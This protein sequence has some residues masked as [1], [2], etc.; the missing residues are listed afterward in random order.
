MD[1]LSV[2]ADNNALARG[3]STVQVDNY[4]LASIVFFVKKTEKTWRCT[5]T[6]NESIY[7][8]SGIVGDWKNHFTVAQSADYDHHFTEK[9]GHT[10]FTY[11]KYH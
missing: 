5:R 8:L 9:L 6:H 11:E 3:L 10:I 4:A 7:I 2:P 1:Y